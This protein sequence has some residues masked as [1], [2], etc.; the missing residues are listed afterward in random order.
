[1]KSEIS[2]IETGAPSQC[3]LWTSDFGHSCLFRIS[4]FEL[5]VFFE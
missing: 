1:L 4:T 2:R 3:T 5:R